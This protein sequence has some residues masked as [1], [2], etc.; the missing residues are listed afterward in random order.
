MTELRPSTAFAAQLPT[1]AI[2]L[3]GTIQ[4][5]PLSGSHMLV[6][7]LV[8]LAKASKTPMKGGLWKIILVWILTFPV[9]A[10]LAIL[11]YFPVNS[12]F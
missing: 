11:I 10:L 4:K 9:S 3:F 1:A 5:I 8:G 6:A 2:M 12:F 7:S